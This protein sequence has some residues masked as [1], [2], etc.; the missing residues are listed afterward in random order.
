MDEAELEDGLDGTPKRSIPAEMRCFDTARIFVKAG[1]GGN[2]CVAFRCASPLSAPPTVGK[3][4]CPHVPRPSQRRPL[5]HSHMR[6]WC[7]ER[8]TGRPC[9]REKFVEHGGPSG[10][11]GGRGG[12]V[13]AVV[14]SGLNSL[15]SF[16][17]QVRYII[18]SAG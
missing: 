5:G 7:L 4:A 12:N 16:R 8:L 3:A 6:S 2:G 10:G 17:G 18:M 15:S 14:D 9:R 11:C 1:D 13:W